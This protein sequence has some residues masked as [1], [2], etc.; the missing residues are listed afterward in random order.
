MMTQVPV[1]ERE[2]TPQIS[3][4]P[5]K[6]NVDL[7]EICA[8]MRTNNARM[9]LN[10]KPDAGRVV[11]IGER[12]CHCKYYFKYVERVHLYFALCVHYGSDFLAVA[13]YST[14]ARG[15]ENEALLRKFPKP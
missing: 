15:K 2:T 13:R 14:E 7:I 8:Q 12:T 9:E 4:S 1:Y 6:N 3:A 11:S 10:C 5:R